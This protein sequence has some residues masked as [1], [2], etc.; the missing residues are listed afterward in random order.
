MEEPL[1]QR[2][3]ASKPWACHLPAMV[4]WLG[5]RGIKDGQPIRRQ[6][7]SSSHMAVPLVSWFVA[8]HKPGHQY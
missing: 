1:R 2:H 3:V 8:A 5:L 7:D 6:Q 4:F